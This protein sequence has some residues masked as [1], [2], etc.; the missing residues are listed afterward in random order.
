MTEN[1]KVK[2]ADLNL[3]FGENQVVKNLNLEIFSNEILGIIGPAN[4][5][6]T[7]FLRTINRLNDLDAHFSH[8]GKLALDGIDV[9]DD[10][11][12]VNILRKQVGMVF[13]LP[14]PLPMSIYE[15]IVYGPKRQG[16]KN[17]ARLCEIVEQSLQEAY[18]WEEVKDRLDEQAMKLSGGQ[19]QRLCI[20]RALA[21]EPEII[22][23]DEPS[24][25]LDPISTSKVEEAMVK[26]KEKYT[27]VLVTNHT[28]QA[29]RVSS[30]VAFFLMGEMVEIDKTDRIFT[31]PKDPRTEGY[32]SG[33]FG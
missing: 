4:S 16:I 30:R 26:L 13:A 27:I 8:N 20:A 19:Q 12:D 5:G 18:L 14:M 6:K 28:K 21:L 7:T 11:M 31:N 32:I 15:N 22:L 25:G 33:K 17:R 23:F 3:Y 9:Y 24:S 1:V 2:A 29:A 10:S